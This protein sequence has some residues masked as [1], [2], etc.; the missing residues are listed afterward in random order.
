MTCELCGREVVGEIIV[1]NGE[2]ADGTPVVSLEETPDRDWICCDSCN[3][4][5]VQ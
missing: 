1:R 4:L 3:L 5:A 2:L